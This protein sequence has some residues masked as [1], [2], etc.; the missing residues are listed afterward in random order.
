MAGELDET[1]DAEID[2]EDV[3]AEAPKAITLAV[4]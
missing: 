4:T 3:R 1:R 2:W